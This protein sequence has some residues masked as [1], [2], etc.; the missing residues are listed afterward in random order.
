MIAPALAKIQSKLINSVAVVGLQKKRDSDTAYGG[1]QTLKKAVLY[2]AMNPGRLKI[3]R[4][5]I[6][7][8]PKINPVN[9]QWTFDFQDEG[10]KFD[11]I[12]PYHGE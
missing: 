7:A 6:H 10:T 4:A 1:E 11:N 2:I 8:N 5:K 3:V 9:M 12:Q